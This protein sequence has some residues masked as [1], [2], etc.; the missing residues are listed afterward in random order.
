MTVCPYNKGTLPRGP[1]DARERQYWGRGIVKEELLFEFATLGTAALNSR[2]HFEL[3]Q[4]ERK[5]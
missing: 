1:V 2:L 3:V 4:W 5:T